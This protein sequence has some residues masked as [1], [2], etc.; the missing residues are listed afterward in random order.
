MTTATPFLMFQGQA[1]AAMDFYAATLPNTQVVSVER[2][3]GTTATGGTV[4]LARLSVCGREFLVSDSPVRHA[5]DFTP[6]C[7][8][9]VDCTTPDE[10]QRLFD[11]LADGGGVLMPLNDYGFS[12]RFGWLADR[13]G[14][15]WQ[16]NLP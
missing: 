2:H 9:F 3:G 4:K 10:Q 6:A 14:V 16:I 1:Q 12:Q 5:F 11:A 15:S 7:S 8:I 13:F